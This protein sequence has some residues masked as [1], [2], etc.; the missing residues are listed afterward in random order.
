MDCSACEE[1]E[2]F[3][4]VIIVCLTAVLCSLVE[5]QCRVQLSLL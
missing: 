2:T 3:F 1:E 5:T 4:I